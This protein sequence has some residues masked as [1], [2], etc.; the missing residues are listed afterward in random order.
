MM[1]GL[2]LLSA[3]P[4]LAQ[5]LQ[6]EHFWIS[7]GSFTNKTGVSAIK[8]ENHKDHDIEREV[9]VFNC[10]LQGV[11]KDLWRTNINPDK[12]N[13]DIIEVASGKI[14]YFKIQFKNPGCYQICLQPINGM[15][16]GNSCKPVIF[17]A[18]KK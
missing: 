9:V 13:D 10:S 15:V 16:F 7:T 12:T 5:K 11:P 4:V 1:A 8:L 18:A 14:A 3:S 6:Y 17:R 2:A